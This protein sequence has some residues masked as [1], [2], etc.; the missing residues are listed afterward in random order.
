LTG[1]RTLLAIA[2]VLVA[3]A[4]DVS[5]A[6]EPEMVLVPTGAAL[7]GGGLKMGLPGLAPYDVD[8]FWID[9]F[10]VT[11]AA[12]GGFVTATGHAPAMFADDEEFNG[13]DLPVTGIIWDDA[14]AYCTWAG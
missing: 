3:G 11:N 9:R 5:R 2:V 10:E 4:A 8:G 1:R 12:F 14:N 7:L 6:S 13:A